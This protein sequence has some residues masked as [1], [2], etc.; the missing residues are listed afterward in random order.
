[1]ASAAVHAI[2]G[3]A[4]GAIVLAA[5]EKNDPEQSASPLLGGLGG[6]V[7]GK[8]PDVFEPATS[9]NHRRF[10]HSVAFAVGVGVVTYKL[11]KWQPTDAWGEFLRVL[12][13]A[14]GVGYLSHLLLD[15][16]TP[17]SLPLV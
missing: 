3:V 15:L 13:V 11:Y 14:V 17:K 1:M 16:T 12:G 7:G 2:A 8:L 4:S 10:C 9:P 6:L 5:T